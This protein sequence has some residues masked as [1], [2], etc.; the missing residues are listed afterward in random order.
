MKVPPEIIKAFRC[1]YHNN[2]HMIRM[3]GGVHESVHVTS[4]VRQ[5]CPLSPLL[6]LLAIEPLLEKLCTSLPDCFFRAYADDIGGTI[7]DAP[8]QLPTIIALFKDFASFSGLQANMKK[9]TVIP[10]RRDIDEECIEEY[11]RIVAATEWNEME[12]NSHSKY[13]GFML[14]SG[15]NV[16]NT[17]NKIID[18]IKSRLNSWPGHMFN[19]FDKIRVWNM[20]AMSMMGYVDQLYPFHEIVGDAIDSLLT[21]WI[22]GPNGWINPHILARL[23]K[24]LGFMISPRRH[25]VSNM[26]C[27]LYTSP[28]PRD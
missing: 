27:L 28:S 8:R 18:K 3:D 25:G 2:T 19:M 9:T 5:G 7:P 13:L 10:A 17:Y 11:K 23:T 26:A 20:F 14:G 24:D 1:L 6:F 22:G 4:G 21:K 16:I 15:T 12:V